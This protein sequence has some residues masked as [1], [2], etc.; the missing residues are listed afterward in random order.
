MGK[1]YTTNV[2]NNGRVSA[3]ARKVCVR[4]SKLISI[5]VEKK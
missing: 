5:E 4:V 1:L 3:R 2:T